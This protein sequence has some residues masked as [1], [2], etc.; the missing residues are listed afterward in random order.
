M[1]V[2]LSKLQETIVKAAKAV[3]N[4]GEQCFTDGLL[5]EQIESGISFQIDVIDDSAEYFELSKN[6]QATPETVRKS[7]QSQTPPNTQQSQSYGRSS[8]STVSYQG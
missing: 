3:T 4:A 7:T 8:E 1:A 2:L 5:F 6:V